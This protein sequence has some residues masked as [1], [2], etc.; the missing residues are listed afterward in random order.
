MSSVVFLGAISRLE[1]DINFKPTNERVFGC[2]ERLPAIASNLLPISN[3]RGGGG[4][5]EGMDE[6][7]MW[8]RTKR[9]R[10]ERRGERM[11]RAASERAS[12]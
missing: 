1:E 9:L 5:K 3:S 11:Q 10:E 6:E 8:I 4:G 2:R 7:R 12:E